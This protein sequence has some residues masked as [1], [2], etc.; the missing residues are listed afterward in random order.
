[1]AQELGFTRFSSGDF[2][3]KIALDMGISLN[4]L[5]TIAETDKSIDTKIDEEVKKAGEMNQVVIDSRLAFHWIPN[6]FK[7]FLDLPADIAKQRI[8]NN[9]KVNTL[10]QQSEGMADVDEVYRK[11]TERLDSEKKRYKELYNIDHTDKN[12]FD[13]I[14]DTNTNNLEQVVDIIVSEYKKR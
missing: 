10:R 12:N 1:V 3:R 5:S 8:S 7:V 14:I 11:I 9:L 2:M 6:S 13:L 4:E